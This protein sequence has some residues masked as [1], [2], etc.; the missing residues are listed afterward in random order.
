MPQ[1]EQNEENAQRRHF[2]G[3]K[4][5][6][7]MRILLSHVNGNRV[8]SG[9]NPVLIDPGST[10]FTRPCEKG[11]RVVKSPSLISSWAHSFVFPRNLQCLGVDLTTGIHAVIT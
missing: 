10:R 9:S 11:I 6:H 3:I 4:Y 5:L 8:E 7:N 2:P 1:Q